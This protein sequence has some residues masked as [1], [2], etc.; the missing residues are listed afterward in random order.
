MQK[1][2]IDNKLTSLNRIIVSNETKDLVIEKE[3]KKLKTFD[4]GCLTWKNHF[5]ESGLQNYCIFQPIS[6]Y[7]K[8][9]NANNIN[10]ILS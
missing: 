1:D 6:K 2:Y 3:L 8:V 10:Y 4:Q 9:A 5:D 7:L